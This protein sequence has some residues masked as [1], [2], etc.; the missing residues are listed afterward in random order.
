MIWWC[1]GHL[2]QRG[3][4]YAAGCAVVSTSKILIIKYEFCFF[5][6]EAAFGSRIRTCSAE[7]A[8]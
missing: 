3:L 8:D 6:A 2:F 5:V 4:C 7:S 1:S